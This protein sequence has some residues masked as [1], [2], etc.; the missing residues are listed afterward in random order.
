M[1]AG[2]LTA[3]RRHGAKPRRSRSERLRPRFARPVL[4]QLRCRSEA[5]PR[6]LCVIPHGRSPARSKAPRRPW[7]EGPRLPAAKRP[8]GLR[9]THSACPGAA[10]PGRQLRCRLPD[11]RSG[12]GSANFVRTS[13]FA[14]APDPMRS[15]VSLLRRLT[16]RASA[17]ARRPSGASGASPTSRTQPHSIPLRP[18]ST[19]PHPPKKF[20]PSPQ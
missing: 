19:R 8:G 5:S 1:G 6:A 18:L 15:P 12:S 17:A 13:G 7:A 3:G 11:P 9:P 2:K 10:K 16:C 14:P 4:R 20:S